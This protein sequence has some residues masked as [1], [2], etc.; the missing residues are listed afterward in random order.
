MNKLNHAHLLCGVA[1]MAFIAAPARAEEERSISIAPQTLASALEQLG[2]QSGIQIISS[3]TMTEGKRTRGV[4]GRL[5][6]SD[7]LRRILVGTD[8]TYK[9]SGQG[10]VILAS[11]AAPASAARPAEP[12]P[13][14]DPQTDPA[15]ETP[16]A[17]IVVTGFRASLNSALNAKREATGVVD[18]IKADDIA[19]FP[20]SNL[21]ESLQRVPGVSIARDGGQGRTI[22]VRGLGPQFTRVRINGMEAQ[23]TSTGTDSSGGVNRG[24]GFDFN[25]FAA[26][27]FNSLTVRKTA[28][29]DVD[30]GSLG[31]TVDL[32]TARPFDYKKLT[33]AGSAEA[34]YNDLARSTKPRLTGLIADQFFDGKL[35]ILVSGAWSQRRLFEDGHGS[36]G[37]LDGTNNSG[38]NPA[39]PFSQAN[40]ATTYSPRFPRY[41]RLTRDEDRLGLT[42][43]IQFK[44][45]DRTLISFDALYS[46]F[47]ST[48][49]ENWLES[50]AFA[51]PKSQGGRPDIIVESGTINDKGDLVKGL[52]DSVDIESEDRIAQS[53]T[54]FQQYT[55]TGEQKFSDSVKINGLVG[56]SR[57]FFDQPIDTNIILNREN[58]NG[59]SYD[60][61]VNPNLPLI[62]YGFDVTNPASFNFGGPR[63]E[64]R[65]RPGSVENVFKNAQLSLTWKANDNVTLVFGGSLKRFEYTSRLLV[66]KDETVVPQLPAGTTLADLTKLITGFGRNLGA[67]SGVPTSWVAPDLNKFADLFDIYS[68][69]G[70]FA[71][72]GAANA[73]ARGSILDIS[74]TDKD[75]FWQMRFRGDGLGFPI[76]GDVGV[77]YV[78]TSQSSGGFQLI[79]VAPTWVTVKRSY[80]D[81]LPSLNLTA[82]VTSKF[83]LRFGAARVMTRPDLGQL[84]PGGSIN[85][86]GVFSVT[87][88][89]P[90]LDPIRADTLDFSAEWYFQKN[91]L[92]SVGIFYKNIETYIQTSQVTMPF[93]Q[94]DLPVGLLAGLPV[95]ATDPFTFKQPVNTPGGPLKGIEVNYQQPFTFLPGFLKHF[96][97]LLNYT[98]VDSKISYFSALSPTGRTT[99]DL[100]GLSKHAFNGTLYYED[101]KLS[102]RGSVAYRGRY[103]TAVPSGTSTNDVD[104]VNPTTTIDVSASYSLTPHI[105]LTLDGQNL[106]DAFNNQFN[107][108]RRE[109][110]F[111]YTHTGREVRAGVRF[112]F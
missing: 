66:R 100:V 84:S 104:G 65:T 68:N 85:T 20:D 2:K 25:V 54:T 58:S 15:P 107:D 16:P 37:W 83:L 102:I 4:S 103:L 74:E 110:V 53:T 49:E 9:A 82:E 31:A 99:N 45:T 11:G 106:T 101:A 88:G 111:V 109:S 76:R 23:S 42:G 30:E 98:Y 57:S 73:N 71:L 80:S 29:A 79:G 90:T 13:A 86:T 93:N 97:V 91:G 35:G 69:T 28:S 43:S 96:G 26:E 94:S 33:I 17:D 5:R 18:V 52:F 24:R 70:I 63:T 75:L 112:S 89:N 12:A 59:F 44:P 105:K 67:P 51:R 34:D 47:K 36:G 108:S 32:Q 14:A 92:L 19:A 55:L 95:L 6:P 3:P 27:L 62:N 40:L 72:G 41:G 81:W 56:Y 10:Y 38:F 64:I 7:A 50:L 22:T 87:S 46:R 78:E 1:A 39:S 8:L 48:R 77:R 60:Y 61:T 21:A